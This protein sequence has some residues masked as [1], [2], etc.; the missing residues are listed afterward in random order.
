[1]CYAVHTNA[2]RQDR[3][4][5]MTVGEVKKSTVF[6]IGFTTFRMICVG[7]HEGDARIGQSGAARMG[8]CPAEQVYKYKNN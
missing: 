1:M 6:M 3:V 4:L 7:K 2:Q 8:F 5:N